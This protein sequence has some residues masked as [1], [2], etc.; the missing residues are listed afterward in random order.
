LRPLPAEVRQYIA[1]DVRYLVEIGRQVRAACVQADILEE[2]LLDCERMADESA[3]RPAVAPFQPKL[4]RG[5]LKP[6]ELACAQVLAAALHTRRLQWAELAN[7]P[8]GRMLSNAA[9]TAIAL[10]TPADARALARCEGVRSG[11]VREHGAEVLAL[12]QETVA[13]VARGEL[14]P[15]P[16]AP[17]DPR[18]ALR[19]ELL[20]TWRTQKAHER[21]VTPSVVLSN[22]N[23]QDLAKDPP[24]TTGA[25]SGLPYFGA[26][27]AALYGEE[28]VDLLRKT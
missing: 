14:K 27:R 10:Q 4:P 2:V 22:T 12:V 26:K 6:G 16:A 24:A 23:V 9:V 1:N 13:Q 11:F 20:K 17:R 15:A 25:L 21:K 5:R 19:Q 3:G 8:M 28:L 18:M 7:I